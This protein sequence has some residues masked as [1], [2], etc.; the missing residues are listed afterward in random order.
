MRNS[1]RLFGLIWLGF[2]ALSALGAEA[3]AV[4]KTRNV[5]LVTLDGM[6]WQE[7]FGGAEAALISKEHGSVANT[8]ALRKTYWRETPEARRAE[9]LPF[10]W[11]EIAKRGQLWGNTNKSSVVKVSNGLNFSYPGYNEMLSGIP[12]PRI[13]SNAKR[14]NPNVTVLE[15]LHQKP[16]Y[17]GRVAAFGAW[18]VFPYILNRERSGL[19]VR[20]GWEPLVLGKTNPQQAL[21]NHLVEDTTP[22]WAEEIFDSLLFHGALDYLQ[23][24]QPRVLYVAFGETDEWAHEGRYDLYLESARR[25]DRCIQ[26]LWETA[27]SLP[28]YRGKTTLLLATDHG[29]GS[30]LRDWRDHGKKTEGSENIWLAALGPDTPAL[31]ERSRTGPLTQSQIAATV[32]A[33]L[34]EDFRAAIPQAARPVEALMGR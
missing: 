9:L 16:A 28:E 33:L 13:D 26:R 10:V 5:I 15:W 29:R 22:Y 27:Q 1:F 14:P 6:R 32:A 31:G 21:L 11:G 24:H 23:T 18:D 3:R 34:G 7:V 25:A 2:L 8:N 4:L 17:R 20:S 12:D 19:H 30:G